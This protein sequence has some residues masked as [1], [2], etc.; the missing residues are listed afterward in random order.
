MSKR[1]INIGFLGGCLNRQTGIPREEHYHSLLK[2]VLQ[3]SYPDI[4]LNFRF[5]LYH[6]FNELYNRSAD[7]IQIKKT[8]I[9]IVFIRPFPLMILNKPIV[10]YNT[11]NQ[12]RRRAI[13]PGLLNRKQYIW[14]EKFSR[15]IVDKT[16]FNDSKKAYFSLRDINLLLGIL[17]GLKRWSYHYIMKEILSILFLCKQKQVELV[18]TGPPQNPESIAGNMICRSL[19][20]KLQTEI[21]SLRIPYVDI[22]TRFDNSD[23]PIFCEDDIHFNENGHI[24]LKD[25]LIEPVSKM[26]E[27]I[28]MLSQKEFE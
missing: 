22:F 11:E 17:L 13:H 18:I 10:K 16:E 1:R 24:F 3:E 27:Q 12:T 4:D 28:I 20:R 21:K 6:A 7:L 8:M 19:N 5:G 14:P 9:L 26:I 2:S 23:I 15:F 25:H